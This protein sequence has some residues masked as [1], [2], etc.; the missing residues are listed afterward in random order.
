[1]RCDVSAEREQ[2]MREMNTLVDQYVAVWNE[3]DAD[4]RRKSITELW[5][6][7]G[8]Q[9]TSPDAWSFLFSR[10]GTVHCGVY[11]ARFWREQARDGKDARKKGDLRPCQKR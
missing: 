1:M 9:F 10:V 2:T 3:P 6:E 11:H 7:D 8:V 5:V 4:L